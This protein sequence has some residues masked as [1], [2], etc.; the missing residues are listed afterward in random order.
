MEFLEG[1]T[2][3]DCLRAEVLPLSEIYKIGIAVADAV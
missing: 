2:L 3:A 1:Q